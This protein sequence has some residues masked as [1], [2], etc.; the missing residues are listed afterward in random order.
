MIFSTD[1]ADMESMFEFSIIPGIGEFIRLTGFLNSKQIAGIQNSAVCWSGVRGIVR[2]VE[3]CKN[4]EGFY[5][6]IYVW[7]ED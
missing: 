5:V 1:T 3:Y 4:D 6:E 7:C 2:S